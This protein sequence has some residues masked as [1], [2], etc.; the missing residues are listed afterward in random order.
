MGKF[1]QMAMRREEAAKWLR[2]GFLSH[3]D[4]AVKGLEKRMAAVLGEGEEMPD[5][6][7][8]LDVLTR[9]LVREAEQLTEADWERSAETGQAGV[10][11]HHYRDPA[12]QE[13]R[14]L[15][16]DV[17]KVLTG[18]YGNKETSKYLGL[19][20]R[21]PRKYDDLERFGPWLLYQLRNVELPESRLGTPPVEKW[22]EQLEP[23][24]TAFNLEKDGVDRTFWS[25]GHARDVF[26]ERLGDFDAIY[27]P[28]VRLVENVY[29]LGDEVKLAGKLRPGF[30]RLVN[31][32]AEVDPD[33]ERET[34]MSGPW[35][36][37]PDFEIETAAQAEEAPAAEPEDDGPESASLLDSIV[38]PWLRKGSA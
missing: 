5:V 14:Q 34:G 11:R 1:S 13:L 18:L 33:S 32:R 37:D 10:L 17:R 36:P 4:S 38:P 15:I 7:H 6:K 23:L 24:V 28:T 20:G 31:R 30:R 29:L 19:K 2:G 26:K 16:V 12:M 9:M 3:G 27:P 25:E 22:V 35:A 21:T 8:F